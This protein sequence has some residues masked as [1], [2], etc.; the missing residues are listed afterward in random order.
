MNGINLGK[1]QWGYVT[2]PPGLNLLGIGD[3]AR[4]N[5]SVQA[6]ALAPLLTS[7]ISSPNLDKQDI[8]SSSLD[9][10]NVAV[11]NYT[12]DLGRERIQQAVANGTQ[13]FQVAGAA[14]E[15]IFTIPVCDVGWT[16]NT[17]V[18]IHKKSVILQPYGVN[19]LL[20]FCN[21]AMCGDDAQRTTDFLAAANMK[22][23]LSPHV[24][25]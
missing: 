1:G 13:Q 23:F 2:S 10:Y 5:I 4:A 8:I 9:A 18:N 3:F 7:L 17:T 24:Y 20:Q 14:W 6:C 12:Y 11:Y 16:I 21:K 25:C 19:K 15:G 22:G